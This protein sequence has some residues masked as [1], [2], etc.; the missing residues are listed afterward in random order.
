MD[1]YQKIISLISPKQK[2]KAL[3][4]PIKFVKMDI[5]GAEIEVLNSLIDSGAHKMIHK[6]AVETH[7]HQIL[8]LKSPTKALKKKIL[9]HELTKKINL[10]WV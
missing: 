4:A 1:D 2:Q 3:D 6:I 9:T 5:E 8:S 7:D 10:G